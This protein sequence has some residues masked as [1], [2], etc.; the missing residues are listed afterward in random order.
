[1]NPEN[2]FKTYQDRS[3]I[4][5]LHKRPAGTEGRVIHNLNVRGKRGNIVQTFPA[6]EYDFFPTDLTIPHGDLVHIQWTGKLSITVPPQKSTLCFYFIIKSQC[7]IN[8]EKR[9]N[10]ENLL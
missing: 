5:L 7:P 1:M 6:T 8:G 3:H 9:M 10:Y 2:Y 4:F